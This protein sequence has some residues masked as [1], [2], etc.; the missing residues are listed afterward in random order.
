M[1]KSESSGNLHQR[2]PVKLS[3]LAAHSPA[4][5]RVLAE[6][7]AALRTKRELNKIGGDKKGQKKPEICHFLALAGVRWDGRDRNQNPVLT[8]VAAALTS[9]LPSGRLGVTGPCEHHLACFVP[10][11]DL[12]PCG[13]QAVETVSFEVAT[14]ATTR[15][16]S[17]RLNQVRV[18]RTLPAEP[19]EME[20]NRED[21]APISRG[22]GGSQIAAELADERATNTSA[23]SSSRSRRGTEGARCREFAHDRSDDLCAACGGRSAVLQHALLCVS[24]PAPL[25]PRP[26]AR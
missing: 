3:I 4:P 14:P 20:E 26:T 1:F 25:P 21:V 15:T 18:P 6:S 8:Y 12:H 17:I 16:K 23:A 7:P 9:A 10:A 22:R 11:I 24:R 5:S 2:S 19:V 13:S